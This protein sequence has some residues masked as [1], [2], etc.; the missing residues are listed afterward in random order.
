MKT[1][2][3]KLEQHIIIIMA[4][5]QFR[6]CLACARSVALFIAMMSVLCS[7]LIH[8]YWY[9]HASGGSPPVKNLIDSISIIQIA[10]TH[11]E[12]WYGHGHTSCSSASGHDCLQIDIIW[13]VVRG[14]V[15]EYMVCVLKW[16]WFVNILM[17]A[18]F[19]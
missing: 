19:F 14:V 2:N 7:K 16:I 11:T 3:C 9:G 4:N 13:G 10:Y 6:L 18:K 15:I 17:R 5:M 12:W 1:Q 8:L